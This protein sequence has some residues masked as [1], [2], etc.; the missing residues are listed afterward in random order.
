MSKQEA[1]AA[2]PEREAHRK[3]PRKPDSWENETHRVNV[4]RE[5]S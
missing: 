3:I 2:R 4:K 1:L 5:V